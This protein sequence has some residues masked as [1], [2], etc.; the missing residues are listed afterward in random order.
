MSFPELAQLERSPSMS[1]RYFLAHLTRK[2]VSAASVAV[3]MWAGG[4]AL[5]A[6]VSPAPNA[7]PATSYP[8]AF[9]AGGCASCESGQVTS[10]SSHLGKIHQLRR[11]R[12]L[13][14]VNLCP[15]ACF[16][17]FQTQ[18]RKWDEVCPYPYSGVGPGNQSNPPTGPL[19]PQPG[20]RSLPMPRPTDP[21]TIPPKQ[22][23]GNGLLPIPMSGKFAPR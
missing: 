21:N 13:Y 8:S 4:S 9:A 11:A 6:D 22:P 16:G 2:V 23:S 1:I 10:G 12:P 18:W 15:G 14:Q 19:I 3:A 17:Y 5:A 20:S 7:A